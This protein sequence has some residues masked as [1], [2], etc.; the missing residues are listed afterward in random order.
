MGIRCGYVKCVNMLADRRVGAV[1]CSRGC[2]VKARRL[3]D[4]L[5]LV[6][7]RR[8]EAEVEILRAEGQVSLV[9]VG[10]RHLEATDKK[11]DG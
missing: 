10:K 5:E 11:G 3:R 7:L 1:Y 2:K 9:S 4:R 6:R 8:G